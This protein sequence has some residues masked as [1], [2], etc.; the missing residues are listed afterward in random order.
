MNH[1]FSDILILFQTVILLGGF[2]IGIRQ[3]ILM[4]NQMRDQVDWQKK[5]VTFDYLY[6]YITQFKDLNTSLQKKINLLKQNGQS[7]NLETLIEGLKDENTRTQLFHLVSY[8]E[9]LAIGITYSYFDESIAKALLSNVVIST[10][11][12]LKPYLL[13]R[14]GETNLIVGSNFEKLANKWS[15]V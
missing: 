3:I 12:S 6:L 14:R 1:Q 15:N 8:F 11:K 13:I 9:N 4:T 2:I 7:A 10:F 5:N